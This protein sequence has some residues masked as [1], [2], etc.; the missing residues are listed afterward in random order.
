MWV[1]SLAAGRYAI[2]MFSMALMMV[3]ISY[4][5][6]FPRD[7]YRFYQY[8][9]TSETRIAEIKDEEVES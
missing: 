6:D 8:G 2:M 3:I 9:T 7:A 5:L 1:Y 4:G